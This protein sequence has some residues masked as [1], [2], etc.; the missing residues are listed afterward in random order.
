V[1]LGARS[2]VPGEGQFA[3]FPTL[4]G[5]GFRLAET[6]GL[7]KT[8][9]AEDVRR[10]DFL[11]QFYLNARYKEDIQELAKQVGEETAR[12]FV[13][14]TQEQ[15]DRIV[16]G[17]QGPRAGPTPLMRFAMILSQLNLTPEQIEKIKDEFGFHFNSSNY[18]LVHETDGFLLYQVLPLKKDV[19]VRKDLKPVLLVPPPLPRPPLPA[20]KFLI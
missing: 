10:L 9:P 17:I 20:L 6:A 7:L 15:V 18:Q 5:S 12:G 16:A 19:K 11:S 8:F 2:L 4:P 1:I 13:Q 14:F 3:G